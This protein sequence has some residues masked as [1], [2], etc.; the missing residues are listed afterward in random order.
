[1]W[2]Q[3][4]LKLLEGK[5]DEL[6]HLVEEALGQGV[7]S[8]E[9]L[10]RGLIPAMER[11]GEL[12]KANEIFIPEVLIASRAMQAALT[13]LEPHLV[14]DGVEPRGVVVLGTV[15]GDLHDI[16]KNL[17][18]MMLRGA[19]YRVVDLGVDVPPER[20]VEAARTE[21][22]HVVGLS[23]LLTTTM[24][25]MKAVID[26]L[27]AAGMNVPVIV[28]GAPL[29]PEFAEGIGA[30]GTAPD[31]ASAVG[32]VEDLAKGRARQG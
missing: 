14:R 16:G 18:G 25:R 9:I 3:I 21:A 5:K 2:E 29:T 1:M 17:V 4:R 23:A 22:A 6:E 32:L 11:V 30:Q 24:G 26:G 15:Q 27:R 31:A 20:F 19:G 8:A 10:D 7:P 13:R 28:G 12:F